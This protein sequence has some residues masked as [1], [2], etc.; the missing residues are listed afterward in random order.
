MDILIADLTGQQLYAIQVKTRA[1]VGGDGGWYMSQKHETIVGERLF[2]VFVDLG[3]P[4]DEVPDYFI[5][6]ANTVAEIVRETHAAW[7]RN[8]GARGQQ[9]SQ[10]NT[11]RRI[12]PDFSSN[13]TNEPPQFTMGWMEP[14]RSAWHYFED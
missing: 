9:R 5:I 8:P 7:E 14:Y 13:Y 6:P 4:K 12:R 3:K 1:S 2:Y 10:T 11:I